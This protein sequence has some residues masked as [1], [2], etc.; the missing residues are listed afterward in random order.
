VVSPASRGGYL[1]VGYWGVGLVVGGGGGYG[2]MGGS[3][4]GAGGG[5]GVGGWGV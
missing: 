4:G 1:L 5:G 2:Y 3:W